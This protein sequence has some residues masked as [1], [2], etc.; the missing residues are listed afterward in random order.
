MNRVVAPIA[1][2]CVLYA[3]VPA[4]AQGV[5]N[6]SSTPIYI[7]GARAVDVRNTSG[8]LSRYTTIPSSS[9]FSTTGGRGQACSFVAG[10]AGVASDGQHYSAGQTVYSNRWL[11]EETTIVTGGET[12]PVNPNVSKGALRDA[13]R[14][15]LVFCDSRDHLLSYLL[16]SP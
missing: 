7:P 12:A 10:T 11:F 6:D 15:F 9:L 14:S 5:G 8:Y 13:V 2:L 4:D 3:A 16:V 1:L